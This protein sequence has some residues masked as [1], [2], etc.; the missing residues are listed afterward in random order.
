MFVDVFAAKQ[1]D[2]IG[3]HGTKVIV[4]NLS[5]NTK[6]DLDINF[7]TDTKVTTTYR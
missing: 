1:F 3:P 6:G 2:D 4:F 7:N 5:R